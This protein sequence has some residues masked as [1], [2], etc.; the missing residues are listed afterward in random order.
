MIIPQIPILIDLAAA[1]RLFEKIRLAVNALYEPFDNVLNNREYKIRFKI[2][3]NRLYIEVAKRTSTIGQ[4][5]WGSFF[6]V[7]LASTGIPIY[8]TN[9]AALAGGLLVGDFYRTGA[10]PDLVAIVH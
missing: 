7:N 8:A 1:K 9:A 10:D 5:A 6:N 3:G 2:T 4:E